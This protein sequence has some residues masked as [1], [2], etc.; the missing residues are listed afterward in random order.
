MSKH[1][2]LLKVRTVKIFLPLKKLLEDNL[3]TVEADI[4]AA[5]IYEFPHL[6]EGLCLRFEKIQQILLVLQCWYLGSGSF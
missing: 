1:N 6:C 2:F 4:N 5:C 3:R